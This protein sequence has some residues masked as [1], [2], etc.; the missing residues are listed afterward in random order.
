MIDLGARILLF[1]VLDEMLISPI[2]VR[3]GLIGDEGKR[4]RNEQV[5]ASELG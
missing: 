5:F 3:V 2:C 4:K 1:R